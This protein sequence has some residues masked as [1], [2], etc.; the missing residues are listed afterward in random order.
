VGTGFYVSDRGFFVTA[1]H[2]IEEVYDDTR[3]RSPLLIVHPNSPTGMFGPTEFLLR[4][5]RECWLGDCAD[6]ALGVA[7]VRTNVFTGE[8]L[9]H[10]SWTLSLKPP[11]LG[12]GIATY[13]FPNHAVLEEGRRFRFA[14]HAF[15]GRIE[16]VG[17]F[18]DRVMAPYPYLQISAR[19]HGAASGGPIASGAHVIGINCTEYEGNLDHPPGPGFGAQ[20]RCLVDAFLDDIVLPGETI[21]RRVTFHD[22]VRARC[23][24]VVDHEDLVDTKRPSGRLVFPH[25]PPTTAAPAVEFEMFA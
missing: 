9:R 6:V 25:M 20:S 16:E 5:I 22:L 18:R 15:G 4:P 1:R 13:A 24:N 17:D 21:A 23:L 11:V 7:P 10:W 12:A 3:Q 8:P 14:P 19:I 2:V